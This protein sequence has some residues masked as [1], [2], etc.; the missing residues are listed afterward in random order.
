MQLES[1]FMRQVHET[2]SRV[3]HHLQIFVPTSNKIFRL[4]GLACNCKDVAACFGAVTALRVSMLWDRSRQ[5]S[6]A[7]SDRHSLP[8]RKSWSLFSR[9][10]MMGSIE[11]SMK[12]SWRNCAISYWAFT[13]PQRLV[14]SCRRIVSFRLLL[15][16]ICSRPELSS[17]STS[18]ISSTYIFCRGAERTC[19]DTISSM[20]SS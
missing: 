4:L 17:F 3:G 11:T 16:M 6:F 2:R 7:K 8:A 19:I 15:Q 14:P 1:S 13:E 20:L 12:I 18:R 5:D 9:P 10:V